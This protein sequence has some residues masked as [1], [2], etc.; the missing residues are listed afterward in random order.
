VLSEE[1]TK[2]QLL[3]AY[4]IVIL[5]LKTHASSNEIANAA[6]IPV[7][8]IKRYLNMPIIKGK[9]YLTLLPDIISQEQL[10]NLQEELMAMKADNKATNKWGSSTLSGEEDSIME[11][12]KLGSATIIRPPSLDETMK[13]QYLRANGDSYGKIAIRTGLSKGTAYNIV[14]TTN[15]AIR[16]K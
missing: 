14:N 10:T 12:R 4:K 5:Y 7:S 2:L 13:V 15:P 1:K 11:I 6:G 8:T 16:S 3:L 9:E